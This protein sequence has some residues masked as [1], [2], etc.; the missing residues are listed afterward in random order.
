MMK[1]FSFLSL[2]I[3]SIVF[4][5]CTNSTKTPENTNATTTNPITK[6]DKAKKIVSSSVANL[7]E[8]EIIPTSRDVK[9]PNLTETTPKRI[10]KAT[11]KE[12]TKA[13]NKKKIKKNVVKQKNT[14]Q[15]K[16]TKPIA[17]KVA[18]KF[19]VPAKKEVEKLEAKVKELPTERKITEKTPTKPTFSHTAWDQMLRKNVSSAGKVNYKA[20]KSQKAAFELYLKALAD[21]PVQPSWSKNKKMAYWI[22]A[23]NAFTIKLIVDNYPLAS[24]T[25][26]HG[27]KP[28]DKKWI[29]LGSKTYSLNNIEND[30]LRPQFKDARIHFAVNCAAKSCPPILNRA[31]TA[32]NLNANFENRAK[33]FVNNNSFNTISAD[34]IEISKI[35]EWYAGDFGNIIDFLNKYTKTKINANAAVSYKAYNWKLNE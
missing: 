30:I 25:D 26:L 2:I 10:E 1:N 8:K 35:F 19:D 16:E 27:G 29:K 6:E 24:I 9:E 18:E 4:L 14:P 15:T 12:T 23:Y 11:I 32:S 34:K 20:F 22:N 13:T 17:T 31:W 28:W 5:A 7:S 33:A 21:N 3:L